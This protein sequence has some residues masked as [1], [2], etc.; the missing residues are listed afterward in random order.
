M[1]LPGYEQHIVYQR[2]LVLASVC[3]VIFL[4]LPLWWKA[5]AV[6]RADLP[7][8]RI[9]SWATEKNILHY[10]VD[11]LLWVTDGATV[12]VDDGMD[13]SQMMTKGLRKQ[14]T[15]QRP[16]LV[17]NQKEQG[18]PDKVTAPKSNGFQAWL[19]PQVTIVSKRPERIPESSLVVHVTHEPEPTNAPWV[20]IAA[21]GVVTLGV[22]KS[23][24]TSSLQQAESLVGKLLTWQEQHLNELV[25][26][27]DSG[28]PEVQHQLRRT[29]KHASSYQ[30]TFSLLQGDASQGTWDWTIEEALHQLVQPL[31][32]EL[33]PLFNFTIDSQTQYYSPLQT[34]PESQVGA[35]GTISYTISTQSLP[36]IVNS[37]DW[38]LDS[39]ETSHPLLNFVL[40]VPSASQTPLKLL[41]SKGAAAPYN[42]FLV[43]R[44]G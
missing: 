32:R 35:D 1:L 41:T 42:A 29:V 27:T 13:W 43:P 14:L 24:A 8:D 18:Q 22:H 25:T 40:Y 10:P 38:N 36:Y 39:T 5:T 16:Y 30:L 3:A 28:T 19:E 9:E 7:V 6:Y 15:A 12:E 21:D 34:E 20:R 26:I 17:S 4:G 11:V 23:S 44:W 37:Q 33:S 31:L 2:R